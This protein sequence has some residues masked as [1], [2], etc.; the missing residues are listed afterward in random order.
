MEDLPTGWNQMR[1]RLDAGEFV[2]GLTVTTSNLEVALMAAQQG[3]H[4]LWIEMEHSSV[5]LETVRGMVLA[6]RGL[7]I[8]VL[9]RVPV[10]ALWTAKRVLDQGV[11]GVIFPF[12]SD[13]ELA[14]TAAQA[15][16]YPPAGL[17]GSGA[18]LAVSTWPEAGNYYDSADA[19]VLVVC[20]V[21]EA[22]ALAHID[23]IVSTPGIDV[24]FIG[25]SDLSFSLGLRGRQ[26]EP[27]LRQ[28]IQTIVD[29]ARRHGKLLGR[30]AGTAEEVLRHR[31]QGFQFF[32]SVTELGLLRLGA[33]QILKP[34]GIAGLP[35][36]KRSLY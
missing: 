32:Q 22:R 9:A 4:F 1:A 18:G 20:V 5:T 34:L 35:P 12:V 6:T 36:D 30:P 16:H 21:E 28:A 27:V 14:R 24:V 19:H 23:E 3:F 33:E 10:T 2:I 29:A 7:D 11:R 26:D 31:E 8:S 17:R 15:C 13:P 25:T